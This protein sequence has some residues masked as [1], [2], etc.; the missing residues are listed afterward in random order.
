MYMRAGATA[1]ISD[2]GDGFPAFNLFPAFFQ[3]FLAVPVTGYHSVAVIDNNGFT[4]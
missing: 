1:G 3:K 4:Q 2:Q